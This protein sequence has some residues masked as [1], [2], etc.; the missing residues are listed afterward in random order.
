MFG[1]NQINL[2]DG[3]VKREFWR[4]DGQ[5]EVFFLLII[6][7][8]RHVKFFCSSVVY[9]N[10]KKNVIILSHLVYIIQIFYLP[11]IY[12]I[13]YPSFLNIYSHYSLHT[14]VRCIC[15]Y[16]LSIQYPRTSVPFLYAQQIVKSPPWLPSISNWAKKDNGTDKWVNYKIFL[17][18][19]TFLWNVWET[20]WKW[21]VICKIG[22]LLVILLG[23]RAWGM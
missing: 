7:L 3:F 22:D 2:Y 18:L 20:F 17:W 14:C 6:S 1:D 15:F 10:T 19:C 5:L 23:K 11:F 8:E 13:S 4:L 12:A 21:D 9:N 16:F